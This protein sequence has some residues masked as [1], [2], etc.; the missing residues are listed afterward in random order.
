MYLSKNNKTILETISYNRIYL[1]SFVFYLNS[2]WTEFVFFFYFFNSDCT[3][4]RANTVIFPE[5]VSGTVS[6]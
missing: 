6:K 4:I 5:N 1:T 3:V 2:S